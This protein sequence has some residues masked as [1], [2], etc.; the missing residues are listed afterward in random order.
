MNYKLIIN[1]LQI[2]YKWIMNGL[3]SHGWEFMWMNFIH[4]LIMFNVSVHGIFPFWHVYHIFQS[5]DFFG[6]VYEFLR[7]CFVPYDS[8]NG[9]D[10]LLR[11]VGTLCMVTFPHPY[12]VCLWYYNW[13]NKPT[14]FNLAWLERWPIGWSPTYL[15][16]I[17]GI[18][19]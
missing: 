9:F 11:Y 5:S 7:D 6:M 12:H 2:N 14:T 16:F 19:L 10:F 17:L 18:H 13:R 3:Q 4:H 1:G 15:P 8:M